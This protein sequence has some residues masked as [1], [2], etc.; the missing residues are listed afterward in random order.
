[1]VLWLAEHEVSSI[2]TL[3]EAVP[4]VEEAF[5]Q[6]GK[7]MVVMPPKLHF[8][9]P[10]EKG[11][12][13]VMPAALPAMGFAGVKSYLDSAYR[14]TGA[15]AVFLLYDARS[16]ELLSVMA[17]NRLSQIR[18][19]AA[20]AVAT[21]YLARQDSNVAGIFGAG[22]HARTQLAA[23]QHTRKISVVKAYSPN[24]EHCLAFS[25][26]MK[27][28]LGIDVQVSS[29]QEI[30]KESDIIATATT[31]KEPVFDGS[32]LKDG[33]HIN[34]MGAGFPSRRELDDA[35]ILRSKIVVSAKERGHWES[36]DLLI[37][38]ARGLITEEKI[39]A[40]LGEIVAG[41]K[42]G[43]VNEREITLFE[44]QG[45][46]M[47]DVAVASRVYE[48]ATRRGKGRQLSL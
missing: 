32:W 26:E 24:K 21:K 25:R 4:L 2:L 16:G 47:W 11:F 28:Q 44:S 19:A 23:I 5:R 8:D 46:A 39:Y 30:A 10:P 33:V 13:R 36:G 40:E 35:T 14:G 45:L 17:A 48:L 9:L 34:A 1:M 41:L 3:E 20:S 22:K 38:L 42:E 27:E 29:P 18:T 6:Q 31:S 15:P 37:P 43:R 7:R 12:M